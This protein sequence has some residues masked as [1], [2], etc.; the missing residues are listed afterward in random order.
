[1]HSVRGAR[2]WF[3]H[4]EGGPVPKQPKDERRPAD[5]FGCAVTVANLATGQAHGTLEVKMGR[6]CSGNAGAKART[7][8]LAAEERAKIATFAAAARWV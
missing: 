8:V 7:K 6:I 4:G 3:R 5:V 2:C 1:M